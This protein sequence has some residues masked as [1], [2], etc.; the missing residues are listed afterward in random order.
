MDKR[1]VYRAADLK[2]FGWRSS[3]RRCY[4]RQPVLL[5]RDILHQRWPQAARQGRKLG[6]ECGAHRN[7]E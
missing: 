3:R 5:C 4:R 2:R 1:L 6:V 7:A